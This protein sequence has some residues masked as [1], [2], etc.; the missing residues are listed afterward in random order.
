MLILL[1]RGDIYVCNP[2]SSLPAST[3]IFMQTPNVEALWERGLIDI[4]I[5]P[6]FVVNRYFYLYY[7]HAYR[8]DSS[9]FRLSR[10][11]MNPVTGLGD[12]ST[13]FVIWE[14]EGN[15]LSY[16]AH[17]GGSVNFGPDSTIYLTIGSKCCG[18]LCQ[19]TTAT[20]GK[21][22]RIH[23][24]GSIPA[25]NPLV[26]NPYGY[27]E[28]IFALGLRNPFRCHI[29]RTTGKFYLSDVGSSNSNISW[30]D[31]H[32]IQ[33]PVPGDS[34]II[35]TPPMPNFG[36]PWHEGYIT[37]LGPGNY[38]SGFDEPAYSYFHNGSEA[39]IIG[40]FA[41]EGNIFPSQYQCGYFFGDY[42]K[43]EI[44]YLSF[45][46]NGNAT[47]NNFAKSWDSWSANAYVKRIVSLIEGPDGALYYINYLQQRVRRIRY[48][49]I[50]NSP[51]TC[52]NASAS[53]TST[54][55][56][57]LTTTFSAGNPTDP[58]SDPITYTWLFGD[59]NSSTLP[60]PTH[61]YT[62][63]GTY[64]ALLQ[65][66]DGLF[67]VSCQT[68]TISIGQPPV[69][70]I[71]S[72]A[73]GA[74][75]HA[76][77]TIRF[78]GTGLDPQDGVLGASQLEWNI[79]FEHNSHTHT[80][81]NGLNADSGMFVVPDHGHGYSE[82]TG[83]EIQLT[84]T[85]SDG[86]TDTKEIHIFPDKSDVT[87]LTVPSGLNIQIEGEPRPGGFVLDEAKGFTF[88][89]SAPSEQCLQNAKYALSGW[90]DG[91]ALSHTYTVPATSD[92]LIAYFTQI[93][94]CDY[95]DINHT[96]GLVARY[97]FSEAGGNTV[98][99]ISGISPR[100]DLQIDT[101]SA[102][103]WVPSGLKVH[104]GT[105]IVASGV[106]TKI[107]AACEATNELTLEAWVK[108]QA[109][110][111]GSGTD[112]ARLASLAVNGW[113][114]NFALA[115]QSNGSLGRWMAAVR[116]TSTDANGTPNF[117]P[118]IGVGIDT[119]LQ[120][121][122][123]TRD[124]IGN[125]RLFVNGMLMGS[126]TRSGSFSNSWTGNVTLC[127]A[128]EISGP[129]RKW[130][131]TLYQFAVYNRSLSTGE[132]AERYTAACGNFVLPVFPIELVQ[133]EGEKQGESAFLTWTIS[134]PQEG[135]IFRI[136][137]S[138]DDQVFERL[139]DIEAGNAVDFSF[140]DEQPHAGM[141]Y[142]R[143]QIMDKDGHTTYSKTVQLYFS[144][145]ISFSLFPNPT[146][147]KLTLLNPANAAGAVQLTVYDVKG[148]KV[149]V[150]NWE[151]VQDNTPVVDISVLPNSLYLYTI[152]YQEQIL[153]GKFLKK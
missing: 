103:T 108:P 69:A 91:K 65:I 13:E 40:G 76:G 90:S 121:V 73:N 70:D 150:M 118:M 124:S 39:A 35:P 47:S 46:A 68:I 104:G 81:I 126:G 32:I 111:Q 134:A 95:C 9:V 51:P 8:A 141:N 52:G 23:R 142:Y 45:D 107:K 80:G 37:P 85:D 28:D 115:Q 56:N 66:S 149:F 152:E 144:A 79:V 36:H 1:K 140:I 125:E 119:N 93:G 60:S 48:I 101:P 129:N 120:Y 18:L 34:T 86:L 16:H 113:Q 112:Y 22:I 116:T 43:D 136:E 67:T 122:V 133:F 151:E 7:N 21:I 98:Y 97:D 74:Y 63:A 26:G 55:A 106:D 4:E 3:S 25:D 75:F 61:T 10:F 138:A 123:Y 42:S 53:T 24:D 11:E 89:I 62:H 27:R 131:G 153:S 29:D 33:L 44:K 41:Y 102:V 87:F 82:L 139:D 19:D 14:D 146:Q 84:A 148:K 96:A 109:A 5:D 30:E 64:T 117:D 57:T 17:Y 59:G 92:T 135:G 15:S 137:R 105:R 110:L 127:L 147:G 31:T 99:D 72:P 38:P 58:N 100:M 78:K 2:S 20:N 77:D 130:L 145:P 143:L 114:R 6:D 94:T 83:Y 12:A 50:N 49:N 54:T 128:N 88:E 71:N 132:I